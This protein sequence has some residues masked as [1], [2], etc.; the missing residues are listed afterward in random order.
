MNTCDKDRE[1]DYIAD[2]IKEN[3][4][5]TEA[6]LSRDFWKRS[7][8][9]LAVPSFALVALFLSGCASATE[10][11]PALNIYNPLVLTIKAGTKVQTTDGIFVAQVDSTF[12]SDREYR[13]LNDKYIELLGKQ[14]K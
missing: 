7:F 2:L 14:S 5:R 11:P 9:V 3:R 10:T 12:W 4:R 6:E 8:Y 13:E 1:M